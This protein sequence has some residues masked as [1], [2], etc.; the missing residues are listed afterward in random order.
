MIRVIPGLLEDKKTSFDLKIRQ[1]VQKVG[2]IHIDI[3]DESYGRPTIVPEQ[4]GDLSSFENI[5]THLMV[6]TPNDYIKRCLR[7]GVKTLISQIEDIKEQEEFVGKVKSE[8]LKCGL[9]F[10][11][12]TNY[13]L[14]E[15][16]IWRKL[17]C[18]LL[19]AIKAGKSGQKFNPIVLG[20]I[21]WIRN[22]IGNSAEI[23]IDGG[24]NEEVAK[25]ITSYDINGVISNSYIWKDFDRNYKKLKEL[26][27]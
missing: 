12:G 8:G 21:I 27:G 16:G 13:E 4:W 19:M 7:R 9:A 6:A 26:L 1:V 14:V 15:N 17:D 5:S 24:I 18:V 22:K 20:E 11:M 10:N 25:N 2:E 3:V 23:I